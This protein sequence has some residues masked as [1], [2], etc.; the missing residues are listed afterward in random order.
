MSH[1]RIEGDSRDKGIAPA[2]YVLGTHVLIKFWVRPQRN[3]AIAD[4]K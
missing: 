1:P 3:S 2:R 4:L